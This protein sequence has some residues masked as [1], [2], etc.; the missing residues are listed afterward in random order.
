[1][2]SSRSRISSLSQIFQDHHEGAKRVAV[3]GDDHVL[4]GGDLGPDRLVVIG[5]HARERVLQAFA[6]GWRNVVGAAPELNLGLAP[7]LSR[8]VL[9]EARQRAVVALV[10]RGVANDR[11]VGLVKLR[12]DDVERALRALQ[13]AREGDIELDA[14][15]ADHPAR[16]ARLDHAFLS[17][18][19][20]A[21]AREE[22]ELVPLALAVADKHENVVCQSVRHFLIPASP[23][24]FRQWI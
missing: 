4:A 9:V 2:A 17:Q 8:F 6:I 5:T 1:M 18:I 12:Q 23:A 14:M 11:H 21:P 7:L 19:R 24:A 15:V 16:D 10:Q 3:R 13:S 22:I 20:I